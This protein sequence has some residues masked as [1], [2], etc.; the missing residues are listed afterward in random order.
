MRLRHKKALII[1]SLMWILLIICLSQSVGAWNNKPIQ[2]KL[3]N[4]IIEYHFKYSETE[5]SD[6]GTHDWIADAALRLLYS[7]TPKS[8]NWLIHDVNDLEP[9]KTFMKNTAYEVNGKHNTVRSYIYF[10]LASQ[11]PDFKAAPQPLKIENEAEEIMN[12]IHNL[13]AW[14]GEQRYQTYQY[15][16]IE[17]DDIV[18][19]VPKT[20]NRHS[21][22]FQYAPH[23]ARRMGE[24]AVDYL[25]KKDRDGKDSRTKIETGA[26][27]L[28]TMAHYISDLSS[29]PHLLAQDEGWYV[30]SEKYHKWIENQPGKFSYWNNEFAGPSEQMFEW[31]PEE[32][33][34][35]SFSEIIAIPPGDAAVLCSIHS[36]ELAFGNI[37]EEKGL[38]ISDEFSGVITEGSGYYWEWSLD[39]KNSNLPV[40]PNY[41]NGITR[42]NFIDNIEKLLNL[43][44][45]Y[46]ACA[47]LWVRDE[48]NKRGGMDPDDIASNPLPT[49]TE[50]TDLPDPNSNR[51]IIKDYDESYQLT[52]IGFIF[53]MS[54]L[55]APTLTILFAPKIIKYVQAKKK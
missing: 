22:P 26:F 5:K 23:Y 43:A 41:P 16:V 20:P 1:V 10:L 40:H 35:E 13:R 31:D 15:W 21:G 32:V 34:G 2:K 4:N 39:D 17:E 47:M 50:P 8:W 55:S 12:G 27:Y 33:L 52:G 3:P 38:L 36:L 37:N 44:V 29:P 49:N 6:Y 30:G 14:I 53:V 19:F 7:S 48:V 51:E 18:Y 46:T 9:D 11:W 25:A 54:A 24:V 28:G 42:K 45:Y